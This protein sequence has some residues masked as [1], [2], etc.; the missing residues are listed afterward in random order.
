[1]FKEIRS[2]I[3]SDIQHCVD[4]GLRHIFDDDI[5]SEEARKGHQAKVEENFDLKIEECDL[6][7]CF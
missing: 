7:G 3:F 2:K 4:F 5:Q 6:K 1:M